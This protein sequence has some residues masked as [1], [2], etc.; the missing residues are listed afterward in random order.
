MLENYH[1]KDI[2]THLKYGWP[3]NRPTCLPDP[4]PAS[5]NHKGAINYPQHITEYL[6]KEMNGGRIAGPY[7]DIPF[8]TRVGVSPMNSRPKRES[9]QRR[10]IID[11]SWPIGHSVNDGI[12]KDEYLG[13][14]MKLRFPTI[15]TFAKRVHQVGV[16]CGLFKKDMTSAFRQLKCDPFDYTLM[17][18]RWNNEYYVDLAVAMGGR[19][20]PSCCQ[21]VSS[22]IRYIHKT[23]KN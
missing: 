21:R 12:N 5:I 3:V 16:G 6:E 1:D 7:K 23:R 2:I 14:Y 18:Y 22:A 13:K 8:N 4:V 20:A 9:Q 11:F 17:L 19:A 10:I 15:D